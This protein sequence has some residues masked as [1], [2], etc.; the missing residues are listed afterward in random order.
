MITDSKSVLISTK[1]PVMIDQ[2]SDILLKHDYSIIIEKSTSKF[3]LKVL[4]QDIFLIIMDLDTT[5][6]SKLDLIKIIKTIRPRLPII[7][8][9]DDDTVESLRKLIQVGVFYCALKPIQIEEIEKVIDS[10]PKFNHSV[11][12]LNFYGLIK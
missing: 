10:L 4:E 11:N 3:I 9:S 2:M 8:L 7:A 1:D 6:N 12:Y 5:D